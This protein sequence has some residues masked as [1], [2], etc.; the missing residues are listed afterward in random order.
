[1]TERAIPPTA[2]ERAAFD[3]ATMGKPKDFVRVCREL[4]RAPR[5]MLDTKDDRLGRCG[6]RAP[7]RCSDLAADH[8][9]ND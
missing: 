1:M 2:R 5:E 4:N 6:R 7:L 3:A 9:V 8:V